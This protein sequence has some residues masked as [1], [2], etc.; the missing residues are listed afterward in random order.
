MI[1]HV[2]DVRPIWI[3]EFAS[4]LSALTPT[5]GWSPEITS[6]GRFRDYEHESI[7][8]DPRLRIR[9]FPLQR[10]FAK[11]PMRQ[12]A[13][14]ER[15]LTERLIRSSDG[16]DQPLLIT[17]L[18][19]Y[20]SVAEQWPGAV[21]YY[22]TDRFINYWKNPKATIALEQQM[23]AAAHL[24]C[25]N[26][27]RIADHLISEAQCDPRKIEIV[28]NATREIN[29]KC[30]P[31]TRRPLPADL[32]N[33]TAPTAGIL[34]NLAGNTDWVLLESVIA[35][36]GWLSWVFVGPTESA[37]ADRAQRDARHRLQNRGGRVRFVGPKPY[38][39]L[40]DYARAFDVA[41]LPYRKTEPTF[42]GSS[43]RFY[44]HLPAGKPM[45]ATRG[46]EE[47]LHKE[48][49]LRL[50]ESSDQM[51]RALDE[52]RGNEFRDGYELLRWQTSQKETWEARANT[53]MSALEC[54]LSRSGRIANS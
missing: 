49:L 4:A 8:E 47:L 35:Q 7:I 45:I 17:C 40:Q 9:T 16:A 39:A 33:V 51:V 3:K 12:L 2:L 41:I 44:E 15:R 22:V 25:P 23:C 43:T 18:P 19:H 46:F 28:P 26:S 5:V 31:G 54:R 27:Q 10:G 37:I 42:S 38:S 50:V 48:P 14:E 52:L 21:I 11:P 30:E 36:T 29:V 32:R 6:T 1:A 34:G 53:M 20:A 24:V 13:G